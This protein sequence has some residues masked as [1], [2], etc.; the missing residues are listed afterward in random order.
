MTGATLLFDLDGTLVDT[1]E[2]H[3]TAFRETMGRYGIEVTLDYY[4][5]NHMDIVK[6]A[7][8]GVLKTEVDQAVDGPYLCVGHLYFESMEALGA[9]MGA[10]TA[11]EAMADLPNFTNATPVMQIGQVL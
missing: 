9:A 3:F 5:A 8:P 2:L 6:R 1:D 7:M 11:G 10:P 4:K